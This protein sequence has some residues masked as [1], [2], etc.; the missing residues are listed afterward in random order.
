MTK[1]GQDLV[2]NCVKKTL[3]GCLL[4]PTSRRARRLP[5]LLNLRNVTGAREGRGFQ[6][7]KQG[8]W[9]LQRLALLRFQWHLERP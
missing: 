3:C 5:D 8:R 9:G 1:K 6:E 2:T 7:G 4:E